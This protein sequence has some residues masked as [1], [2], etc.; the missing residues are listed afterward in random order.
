MQYN[1]IYKTNAILYY[2][3]LNLYKMLKFI[4]HKIEWSTFGTV[5]SKKLCSPLASRT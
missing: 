3:F 1:C 5:E 4:V 2:L